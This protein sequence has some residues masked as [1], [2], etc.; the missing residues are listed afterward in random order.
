LEDAA[1]RCEDVRQYVRRDAFQPIRVRLKDGRTFD[2]RHPN[3]ALVA[4]AVL[5]IGV[6]SPDDPDSIYGDRSEWIRYPQIDGIELLPES[7][8]IFG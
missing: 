1:M 6:P 5:I 7:A 4:E 8:R 3:H 2:I